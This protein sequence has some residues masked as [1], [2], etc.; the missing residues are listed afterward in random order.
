MLS[1]S[2]L[3]TTLTACLP[4]VG[5]LSVRIGYQKNGVLLLAHARGGMDVALASLGRVSL[6]WT[7]FSSGPPM[8]EAMRAGDIDVGA[9]GDTPP[10]FAQAGGAPIVYAAAVP[11]ADAAEAVIVPA[12]SPV[13]TLRDLEGRTVALT[14]ASTAHLFLIEALASVGM[15][16]ADVRPAYLAPSDAASA[17][18]G[19]SAAAWA[20][21]DPFLA[22]AEQ[23]TATRSLIKRGDLQPGNSFIVAYRP[24]ADRQPAVLRAILDFLA[25]TAAWG[26]DHADESAAILARS[27]GMPSNVCAEIVR[28]TPS[29]IGPMSPAVIARQQAAADIFHAQRFIPDPVVVKDAVWP[30]WRSSVAL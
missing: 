9:V 8:L 3:A 20:I 18:S 25:R 27:T 2:L 29:A 10:I 17:F 14:R 19:G 13:R 21:W 23:R 4:R 24:F 6:Q 16:M 28:R 1:T 15:S 30:G 26:D 7:Q 12:G 5:P 11:N 22:L